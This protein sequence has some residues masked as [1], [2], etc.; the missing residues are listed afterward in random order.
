MG[1]N[2]SKLFTEKK[3][4][5]DRHGTSVGNTV[6]SG[7][8]KI[9][10]TNLRCTGVESKLDDCKEGGTAGS[11]SHSDDVGIYCFNET[12]NPG[13]LRLISGRLE[14]FYNETW[15]TVCDDNF[16]DVD[17]QVACRELGY[18]NGIFIGSTNESV[19]GKIWLDDVDCCGDENKFE[20]CPHA[21]W[22]VENCFKGENV[23]IK[24]N[25]AIEGEVRNSSGKLEILHNSE[26]G[27]VCRDSFGEIEATVACKQLAYRKG[28]VLETGKTDNLRIWL[29]NLRC[30]GEET[31][32]IDCSHDDWGKHTCSHCNVAGLSCS[33]TQGDLRINSNR[34][35]MYYNGTWGTVCSDEFDDKDAT[36]A[37][38]QLGYNTGKSLGPK[39]DGQTGGI[40]LFDMTCTGNELRLTDCAGSVRMRS[41]CR[42]NEVGIECSNS[43]DGDIRIISNGLEIFHD[44]EWGTV[45]HKYFDETDASVACSQ[46]GY[47]N[48]DVN[49][50]YFYDTGKIW[51]TK[52]NCKGEEKKLAKCLHA[53]WGKNN[54]SRLVG[55]KIITVSGEIKFIKILQEDLK[56]CM[57]R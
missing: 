44:N 24:C 38:R 31:K 15:G 6:S 5:D 36:V 47:S 27:T 34:L 50:S 3:V 12:I 54:C 53:E 45:C 52:V 55:I 56:H 28:D 14:I 39:V 43:N 41:S 35:E 18:N 21:K 2:R 48:G 7:T 40:W 4:R 1:R 11:C 30:N 16:D 33:E 46:L 9:W 22:G 10:K 51:L 57:P 42:I 25:N 29:D 13:D 17:A 49:Y 8:G 20:H 32:L 37:C 19:T 26:W 23:K